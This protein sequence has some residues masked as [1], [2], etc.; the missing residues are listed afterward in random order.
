MISILKKSTKRE[1][2]GDCDFHLNAMSIMI[3]FFAASGHNLY[4]KSV[5]ICLQKIDNLPTTN[6]DI[7]KLFQE[8]YHVVIRIDTWQDYLSI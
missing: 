5:Y 6:P 2:V 3:P 1:K 8:G 7:Y 4:A